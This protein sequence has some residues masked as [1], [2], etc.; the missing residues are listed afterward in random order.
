[1]GVEGTG[2]GLY[3]MA[4]ISINGVELSNSATTA[5]VC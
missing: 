2:S 4:G 5:L 1:M 3:H